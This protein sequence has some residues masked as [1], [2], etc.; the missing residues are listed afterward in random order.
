MKIIRSFKDG[1]V[2]VESDEGSAVMYMTEYERLR[3]RK[4]NLG[5]EIINKLKEAIPHCTF[6]VK[7]IMSREHIFM[8]DDIDLT[9]IS[10]SSIE[11]WMRDQEMNYDDIMTYLDSKIMPSIL[12]EANK[13]EHQRCADDMMYFLMHYI[14]NKGTK[15]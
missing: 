8:D 12:M 11:F 7:E 5:N 9:N 2:L 4:F 3:L 13:V 15:D 14:R 1:T 10:I 6:S